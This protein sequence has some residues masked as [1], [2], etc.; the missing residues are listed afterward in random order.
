MTS[1]IIAGAAT[2][3]RDGFVLA[4]LSLLIPATVGKLHHARHLLQA[5]RSMAGF[6]IPSTRA[7]SWPD[8]S[9]RGTTSTA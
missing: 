3:I 5:R 7:G 1:R 4:S 2:Q 6:L 8:T 9:M